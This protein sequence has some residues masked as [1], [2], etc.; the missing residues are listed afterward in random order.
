VIVL[1]FACGPRVEVQIE[2]IKDPDGKEYKV[3]E[4]EYVLTR[5]SNGNKIKQRHGFMRIYYPNGKILKE[6]QYVWGVLQGESRSYTES[7]ILFHIRNWSNGVLDGKS[8]LYGSEGKIRMEE[9]YKNGKR[10]GEERLY[11][12]NGKI[13]SIFIYK[14]DRLWQSVASYDITGKKLDERSVVEGNGVLNVW[15]S[16][17]T[18]SATTEMKDGLPHGK[19]RRYFA[20]GKLEKEYDNREGRKNGLFKAF[21]RNGVLA[22][23]ST[24]ENDHLIGVN[25]LYD[26]TGALREELSYKDHLTLLE[27][28]RLSDGITKAIGKGPDAYLNIGVLSGAHRVYH[29]NGKLRSEEYYLDNLLDSVAREYYDNGQLKSEIF[30]DSNFEQASRYEKFFDKNGKL[31][32]S[33]SNAKRKL[34]ASESEPDTVSSFLKDALA[35]DR[36]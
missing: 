8:I 5:G 19:A 35:P 21:H 7:G 25:R 4:Y 12:N 36:K 29:K 22:R 30:H 23:E 20:N 16:R 17:N 27:V 26:S 11:F 31:V 6:D 32:K 18:L 14:D 15:N 24:Y 9:N 10:E 33:T 13:E 3:S 1:L 34:H 2:Y 28:I